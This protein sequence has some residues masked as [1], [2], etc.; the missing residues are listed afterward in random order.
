MC[1]WRPFLNLIILLFS[2]LS[3]L[4]RS[5]VSGGEV[6]QQTTSN[7]HVRGSDSHIEAT[8]SNLEVIKI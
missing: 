3:S 4:F 5:I 8:T 7:G 6:L 2:F 1:S